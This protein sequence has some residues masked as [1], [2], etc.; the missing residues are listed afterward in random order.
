MA[1][2]L[3]FVFSA[4]LEYAAVN[5]VSRQHKELLRFRRQK[6]KSKVRITG[7]QSNK[8]TTT[9]RRAAK[10]NIPGNVQILLYMHSLTRAVCS[11]VFFE[12]A[13]T[14]WRHAAIA[15]WR[16]SHLREEDNKIVCWVERTLQ[17]LWLCML[18][19][20]ESSHVFCMTTAWLFH[21][22]CLLVI[23]HFTPELHFGDKKPTRIEEG[24]D[25][26]AWLNWEEWLSIQP[27][28]MTIFLSVIMYQ[29]N[30]K[31]KICQG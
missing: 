2:C 11:L 31:A 13:A 20:P 3:L 29:L 1:V 30:M 12:K 8:Q 4:L 22:V 23:L 28:V 24:P 17:R 18:D 7:E 21:D 26:S 25:V 5:F 10:T 16:P 14:V 19:S 9:A 15:D 6:S 27:T